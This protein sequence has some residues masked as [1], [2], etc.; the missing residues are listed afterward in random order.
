MADSSCLAIWRLGQNFH[1]RQFSLSDCE[2][3]PFQLRSE[4]QAR[5]LVIQ[6]E[7]TL[8]VPQIEMY[9]ELC[10]ATVPELWAKEQE[11]NASWTAKKWHR[12]L[13]I[14][15]WS[16]MALSL[17]FNLPCVSHVCIYSIFV[18]THNWS[19]Y[20]CIYA[21]SPIIVSVV[22]IILCITKCVHTKCICSFVY[23]FAWVDCI[24]IYTCVRWQVG[25]FVAAG[26]GESWRLGSSCCEVVESSKRDVCTYTCSIL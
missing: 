4:N 1:R 14:N 22:Y 6:S 17:R 26:F 21:C 23:I 8:S 20:Y 25:S 13:C 15:N 10:I 11:K 18:Y 16:A 2:K 3:P 9:S 5:V 7:E 19:Y 12:I 24:S